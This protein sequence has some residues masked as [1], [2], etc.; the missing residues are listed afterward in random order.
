M[1][2]VRH[3]GLVV[4]SIEKSLKFYRDLLGLKIQGSTNEDENFI[5]EIIGIKNAQLKTLKLSADD[6][7][8]RIEL[9]EFLS[10]PPNKVEKTAIAGW[11]SI[12]DL[13]T[14]GLTK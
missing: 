6:N 9:V 13:V 7:K 5:S 14:L 2:N 12:V 3:V 10:P 1:K 4:E 11:I 8:T